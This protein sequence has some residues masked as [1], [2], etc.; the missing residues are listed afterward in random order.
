[1]NFSAS[2]TKWSDA[3]AALIGP[4]LARLGPRRSC[5]I[6]HCRRSGQVR[7]EASGITKPS[8]RNSDLDERRP[9]DRRSRRAAVAEVVGELHGVILASWRSGAGR[10]AIG[11]PQSASF[12]N[13]QLLLDA[14]RR[15]P[16]LRRRWSSMRGAQLA[17]QVR[18]GSPSPAARRPPAARRRAS[19]CTMPWRLV[20]VPSTSAQAASGS[21]TCAA[22]ASAVAVRADRPPA[23]PAV[24]RQRR[25]RRSLAQH[26][27]RRRPPAAP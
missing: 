26:A 9:S 6:A 27:V 20:K 18:R 24:E 7:I 12:M 4:M 25:P 17:R 14:C 3:P 2:A 19:R 15:R 8:I 22:S 10:A 5:I 13:G 1:M 21:A 11:R 23:P 16:A